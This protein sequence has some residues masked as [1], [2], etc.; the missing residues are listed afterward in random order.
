MSPGDPP[1]ERLRAGLAELLEAFQFAQDTHCNVWNFS[2]ELSE[3]QKAA[4]SGTHLRYL[5]LAG[6]VEHGLERR[7]RGRQLRSMQRVKW[8]RFGE[9]SCFI[10][11]PSGV[12]LARA[13]CRDSAEPKLAGGAEQNGRPS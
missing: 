7:P 12:E 2:I 13:I 10:L 4:L 6:H 9:R 8:L 3:L 5:M 1:A 11:T